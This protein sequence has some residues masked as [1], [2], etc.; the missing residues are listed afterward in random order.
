MNFIH[1]ITSFVCHH[2]CILHLMILS[3][4][5]SKMALTNLADCDNK[6][7]P[8]ESIH[9]STTITTTNLVACVKAHPM[10]LN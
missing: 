9:Q 8:L 5:A 7:D 3:L 1:L 6:M 2:H 10:D 4:V